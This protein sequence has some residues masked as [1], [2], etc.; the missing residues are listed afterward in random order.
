[1][2][3]LNLVLFFKFP[4][5]DNIEFGSKKKST[6]QANKIHIQNWNA[7]NPEKLKEYQ[8]NYHIFEKL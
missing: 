1:M 6:Y 8:K 3:L 2:N 7:K 5:S 4:M